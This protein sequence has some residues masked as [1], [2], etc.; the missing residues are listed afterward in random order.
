MN[1]RDWDRLAAAYAAEVCDIFS[2]DR[3]NV[4]GRWLKSRGLLRHRRTVLDAGCGI[5]SFFRKYGRSFGQKTGTD[6]S[7]RM[8][9]I[10]AARCRGLPDLTWQQADVQKLP[11]ALRD[12]AD[13]VVCSNV[14]TFVSAAACRR[15]LRETR[16]GAKPGGWLL[17]IL[18]ALESHD[19]II[20]LETGRPA[21]RRGATAIVRRDDRMQRFYTRTGARELANRAGLRAVSVQ[22]VWYPWSDEGITRAPRGHE[23]PWDWLL[24]ARR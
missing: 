22:K 2:R 11:P 3:Q 8:L 6:H 21:P 14:I 10:A 4:I 15:A 13:L 1:A 16:R 19:A 17:F 18:P 20:A 24:T 23:P 9:Q 7:R 5:G 12:S